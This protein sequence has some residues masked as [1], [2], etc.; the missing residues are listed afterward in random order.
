M[1]DILTTEQTDIAAVALETVANTLEVPTGT[2]IL[3]L[4]G[5]VGGGQDPTLFESAERKN[6][7][8]ITDDLQGRYD[9]G[10]FGLPFYEKRTG[11][12]DSAVASLDILHR[13]AFSRKTTD[14]GVKLLYELAIADPPTTDLTFSL[15]FRKGLMTFQ[16]SG[17]IIN[18]M[19]WNVQATPDE[20][21]QFRGAAVCEFKKEVRAG[22]AELAEALVTTG[23]GLDKF[24]VSIAPLDLTR[25]FDVGAYVTIPALGTSHKITAI[26]NLTGDITVTPAFGSDQPIGSVVMGYMPTATDAG[27]P[28]S[29]HKGWVTVATV[30]MKI[31]SMNIHLINNR[32][33]NVDEK[34][35]EDFPTSDMRINR[36]NVMLENVR[37]LFN[38]NAAALPSDMA[39]YLAHNKT[40]VA[41]GCDIGNTAGYILD[42]DFP[43]VL[44]T[45][46]RIEADGG[47]N[48]LT[49][50]GVARASSASSL[51]M[52]LQSR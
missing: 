25:K 7:Y 28:V 38:P 4:V 11:V 9:K 47:R 16:R 26:D 33:I 45:Q 13:V 50:T 32:Q 29:G 23:V 48:V 30:N 21:A 14:A 12:V 43:R 51:P 41:M 27:S 42:F 15:F 3:R 49:F 24:N 2:G 5:D 17:C 8:W 6:I 31:L 37:A 22:Y 44:I 20:A 46:P 39:W 36:G 1:A 52:T 10:A 40:Y 35:N 19:N 18:E 34:D